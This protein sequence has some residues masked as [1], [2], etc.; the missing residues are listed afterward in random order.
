MMFDGT[1]R[2]APR[3]T[4]TCATLFDMFDWMFLRT[5][6]LTLARAHCVTLSSTRPG[7]GFIGT[8]VAL[9]GSVY[10]RRCATRVIRRA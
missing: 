5:A 3:V 8:A 6:A 7:M 9:R 4:E 1:L 10:A 2:T